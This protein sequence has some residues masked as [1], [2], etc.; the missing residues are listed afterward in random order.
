MILTDYYKMEKLP[1]V[2][3]PTRLD[4]TVSTG[5]YKP[6]EDIADKCRQKRFKFHYGATPE[7]FKAEAQRKGGMAITNS[8]NISTVYTPNLE[9]P[10]YGYGDVRGTN[11]ALLF[12]FTEDYRVVE[13]FV[14]RG[15]KN[16]KNHLFTRFVE[17][18]LSQEIEALRKRATP[19]NT[20][21]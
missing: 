7:Q 14:A 18:E 13:V 1:S 3:S 17:G 9:S 11:D 19:T 12:L 5:S 21:V 8:K 20:Q 4:C 16:S 6:F 2:K 10:L 15:L